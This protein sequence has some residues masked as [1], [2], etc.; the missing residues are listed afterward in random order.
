MP[1]W[2]V[3]VAASERLMRTDYKRLRREPNL[4]AAELNYRDRAIL[5]EAD[6]D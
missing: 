3:R 6:L 5:I 1:S 4:V 2:T